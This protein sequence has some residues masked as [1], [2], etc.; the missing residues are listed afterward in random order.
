MIM[1]KILEKFNILDITDSVEKYG[2]GPFNRTYVASTHTD[3]DYVL[4]LYGKEFI[5]RSKDFSPNSQRVINEI[6]DKLNTNLVLVDGNDYAIVEEYFIRCYEI[7]KGQTIF[8]KI[9]NTKMIFEMGKGLGIFYQRTKDI[10]I[11]DIKLFD[12]DY[13]NVL[14]RHIDLDMYVSKDLALYLSVFNDIKFIDDRRKSLNL[15]YDLLN[16]NLIPT[17]VIHNNVRKTNF[18]FNY[19]TYD[20]VDLIGFT[21]SIK[22]SLLHDYGNAIRYFASTATESDNILDKVTFNIEYIK[23]F[24]KGFLNEVK[25]IITEVECEN[26]TKSIKVMLLDSAI[27]NLTDYVKGNE[28]ITVEYNT[29]NWDR[30]KNQLKLVEELEKHYDEIDKVIQ[31]EVKAM[32][33]A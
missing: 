17:R 3:H 31:E 12:N 32:T 23:L 1:F 13:H 11:K 33:K 4:Q 15:I 22:G 20:L 25:D 10:P 8:H 16:D 6:K 27:K 19:D 30:C 9:T 26:L 29:Q 5:F 2:S 7:K 21:A 24:T 14:K 28:N 18:I